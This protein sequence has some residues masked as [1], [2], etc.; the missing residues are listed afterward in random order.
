VWIQQEPQDDRL[1]LSIADDG[2]GFDVATEY[3]MMDSP[4]WGLLT[5]QERAAAVGGTVRLDSSPG[6]GTQVVVEIGGLA[7]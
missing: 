1:R 3:Q 7:S 4:H 5:M 6:Y 2:V